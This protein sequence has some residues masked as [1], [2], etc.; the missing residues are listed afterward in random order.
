MTS[1][2]YTHE[3]PSLRSP[4]RRLS[5]ISRRSLVTTLTTCG[6]I[7]QTKTQ[8]PNPLW[9]RYNHVLMHHH[10][11][12]KICHNFTGCCKL[13]IYDTFEIRAHLSIMCGDKIM[14]SFNIDIAEGAGCISRPLLHILAVYRGIFNAIKRCNGQVQWRL[15]HMLILNCH[16]YVIDAH[17]CNFI[18]K[19]GVLLHLFQPRKVSFLKDLYIK[20]IVMVMVPMLIVVITCCTR[21][22]ELRCRPQKCYKCRSFTICEVLQQATLSML[23]CVNYQH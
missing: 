6:H 20:I 18:E 12:K 2:L 23:E 7:Q 15:R 21:R 22:S 16:H 1:D 5:M 10:T 13:S 3:W 4:P 8:T 19:P 9:Q 14:I 11:L 17:G